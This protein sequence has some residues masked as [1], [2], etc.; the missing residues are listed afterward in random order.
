MRCDRKRL[1]K[2]RKK[3][4]ENQTVVGKRAGDVDESKSGKAVRRAY[5]TFKIAFSDAATYQSANSFTGGW[6]S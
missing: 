1:E 3:R 2:T 5:E 6:T 4:A